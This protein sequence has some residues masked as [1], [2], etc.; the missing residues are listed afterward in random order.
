M[1]NRTPYFILVSWLWLAGL[2]LFMVMITW[3]AG[4]LPDVLAGDQTRI[5][6]LLLLLTALVSLHCAYRSYRLSRLEAAFLAW[7]TGE[8]RL[9]SSLLTTYLSLMTQAGEK[10][11]S[12]NGELLA[13]HLH[14]QHAFGWFAAGAMIKLGLLGTVIGFIMML[15]SISGLD[16]L[17]I[18]QVQQLMQ[19]MTQGMMVAL[20]TTLLGLVGSL[21]LGVQYLFL[22]HCA[23]R[24]LVRTMTWVQQV[25]RDQS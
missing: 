13:E 20:N 1:N 21:I 2:L 16:S 18:E 5:S 22:D 3:D 6:I 14:Y 25:A 24:L 23:D 19:Q 7:Q 12:L 4:L 11:L 10:N 17:E 9:D 8:K 15:T